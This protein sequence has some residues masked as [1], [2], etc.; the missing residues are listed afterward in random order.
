MVAERSGGDQVGIGAASNRSSSSRRSIGRR[1]S[2][3][4]VVSGM[5]APFMRGRAN[6]GVNL[7]YRPVAPII[8]W[9]LNLWQGFGQ[10]MCFT[11]IL[12]AHTVIP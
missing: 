11:S 3:I 1:S 2:F 4:H 12:Y 5:A 7:Y 8:N 10:Q 9:Q 6:G